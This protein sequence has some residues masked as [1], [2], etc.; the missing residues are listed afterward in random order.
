MVIYMY[1][2]S[3]QSLPSPYRLTPLGHHRAQ[4]LPTAGEGEGMMN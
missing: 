2:S 4:Q 1:I 3:L